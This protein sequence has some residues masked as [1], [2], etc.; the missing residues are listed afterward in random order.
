LGG[1][2]YN[3]AYLSRYMAPD[4]E[5]ML[6]GGPKEASEDSSAHILTDLGLNPIII[7]EMQREVNFS[8][9]RKA[10]LKIK[11]LIQEF[12]PDIVH[13][14]A[15]KAG[16]LGRLAAS[17]CKVPVIVH[18]FHGHVFHSYFGRV[19]TMVYKNIERY[20]ATKSTR[21]IAISAIQKEELVKEHRICTEEKIEIIPLG[22]DLQKF[23]DG[24]IQKRNTFR[25]MYHVQDD[26]LV[27][28]ILG[29][30]VPIKNHG[31][32]LESIAQVLKQTKRKIRAFVV[33]DGEERQHIEQVA[34]DLNLVYACGTNKVS[35]SVITFTSWIHEAD[36][37]CAGADIVALCSLNEG[38]PVSL[39]EAQAAG[40]PI[41]ST[42]T[43]GIENVVLTGK[44]ALLSAIGD[45]QAFSNN[46]LE[47]IENDTLRAQMSEAGWNHVR[48]AFHYTRLVED[49]KNLY[50][51][52][53]D[54]PR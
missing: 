35:G 6:V 49:M 54:K 48:L 18:T 33:G 42:K 19:K 25:S 1:P 53:L 40:K 30:L 10:Y 37:A 47:L 34:R 8:N 27:I 5:T 50:D 31:M 44:T 29:R 45:I 9:D 51:K 41:V 39:I 46:L 32:F 14:H 13:T 15:S 36:Y 28:M 23:R 7:P 3:V 17:S 43:G 52:L 11:E 38:T 16:T 4:Y 26:E 2:T 21:I 24:Q 20:L 12:K 22:F